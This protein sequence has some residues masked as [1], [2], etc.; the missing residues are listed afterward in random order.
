MQV[1]LGAQANDLEFFSIPVDVGNGRVN[2]DN[3]GLISVS[4]G[5]AIVVE[6]LKALLIRQCHS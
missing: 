4:R 2:V 3:E 5:L 6:T 1:Q